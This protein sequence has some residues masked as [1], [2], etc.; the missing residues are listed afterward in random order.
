MVFC[1]AFFL[2]SEDDEFIKVDDFTKMFI[3][4]NFIKKISIIPG[5]HGTERDETINEQCMSFV[6]KNFD[7]PETVSG[8][9]AAYLEKMEELMLIEKKDDNQAFMFSES[10]SIRSNTSRMEKS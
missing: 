8:T 2:L 1:P 7:D 4:Y 9:K 10:E 3:E 6:L 5:T